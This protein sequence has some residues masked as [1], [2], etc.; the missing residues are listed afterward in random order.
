[1][2]L[3]ASLADDR[4]N[5]RN[6]TVALGVLAVISLGVPAAGFAAVLVLSGKT[7]PPLQG[8]I[9]ILLGKGRTAS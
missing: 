1:M 3:R 7:S 8:S 6:I 2:Y 9:A 4:T 5:W